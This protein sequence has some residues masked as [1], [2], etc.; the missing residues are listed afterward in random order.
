MWTMPKSCISCQHYKPT[1]WEDDEHG[2][3]RDFFGRKKE[4][5]RTP[6]GQCNKHRANVFAT[7][8]CAS[9]LKEPGIEVVEVE[10]R[11][12]AKEPRQESLI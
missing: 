11:P 5:Q 2:Q 10:N 9:F 4:R 1:K 3:W 12:T 8:L 6:A 7:E